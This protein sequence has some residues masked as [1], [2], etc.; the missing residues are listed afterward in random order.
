M[1]KIEI[2]DNSEESPGAALPPKGLGDL[3]FML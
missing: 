1:E 2:K 3:S